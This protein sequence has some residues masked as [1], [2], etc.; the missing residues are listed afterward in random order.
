MEQKSNSNVIKII[1]VIFV[2]I[3]VGIVAWQVFENSQ[4]S[5]STTLTGLT[6]E[7]SFANESMMEVR[8]GM[9]TATGNYQSP[10]K[11]EEIE[12]TLTVANGIITNSVFVSKATHPT[13]KLMQGKFSE[14]FDEAVIGK[15]INDLSLMVVNGSSL[16]PK[17]FMDALGK[18]KRQAQS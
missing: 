1:G 16:T 13:S 8:D 7:T 6:N 14:G 17:G 10:A 12:V 9:Y 2:V 18:I 15:N 5:Q 3:V 4:L 11:R